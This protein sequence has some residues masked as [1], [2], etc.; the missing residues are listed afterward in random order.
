MNIMGFLLL[1]GIFVIGYSLGYIAVSLTLRFILKKVLN[2]HIANF[3]SVLIPA[4]GSIF[5]IPSIYLSVLFIPPLWLLAIFESRDI[6]KNTKLNFWVLVTHAVLIILIILASI[7]GSYLSDQE[8]EACRQ[9]YE[10]NGKKLAVEALPETKDYPL[11]GGEKYDY[12]ISLSAKPPKP[13]Y[14][15]FGEFTCDVEYTLQLDFKRSGE[16]VISKAL[17]FEYTLTLDNSKDAD[18]QY[19]INQVVSDIVNKIELKEYDGVLY[20]HEPESIEDMPPYRIS[21]GTGGWGNYYISVDKGRTWSKIAN[22]T[23]IAPD[24]GEDKV[25]GIF[26]VDIISI[27]SLNSDKSILEVKFLFQGEVAVFEKTYIFK[28]NGDSYEMEK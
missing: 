16:I 12:K 19:S 1:I 13:N 25:R 14:S 5:L 27:K 3:I 23:E 24:G 8:R 2:A 15:G 4:I 26:T 6:F 20:I 11:K 7:I 22:F 18:K 21:G 10:S 17:E 9:K 28:R